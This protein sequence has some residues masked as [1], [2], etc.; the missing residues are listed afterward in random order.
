MMRRLVLI[1]VCLAA[2][3]SAA[4]TADDGGTESPFSL[5]AG[6]RAMGMGNG[7]VGLAD[8]ATAVYYNPAGLPALQTQ[9][10]SFLHTILFEETIYDFVSYVYPHKQ[11]A[12][13]IAGMRLGTDDIGRRDEDYYDLG[14]FDA[15]QMQLMISYGRRIMSRLDAGI[16]LKMAH[17][18][19]DTYSAYGYGL[20]IGGKIALL[21]QLTG[22][23]LLQDVIG[24]RMQL[25]NEKERTPFTLKMGLAYRL[26]RE[27]CPMSSNIVFD[28]DVPENRSTKLRTGLELMH[29]T[30]LSLRGGYDRD[31][32]TLGLGIRYQDLYFDYAYKFMENLDDSHRF[33]LTFN[34][35]LT[36]RE[37]EARRDEAARQSGDLLISENRRQALLTELRAAD[38][39]YAEGQYDSALAAYYRADAHAEDKTYIHTR[40]EDI[41]RR[42]SAGVESPTGQMIIIDSSAAVSGGSFLRQAQ[43]FYERGALVAARDMVDL[44]RRYSAG[45]PEL[46]TLELAV[47]IAI[48][49][50]INDNI[51]KAK[52]A[53][54]AGDYISA[55]DRY[56]TVLMYDPN[57]ALARTGSQMSEKRLDLAQHL[58]L[59]LEYFNQGKYISSQRAFNRALRV[60]PSNQTA[61]EYLQRIDSRIKESTSLDDLQKNARVWQMY[62][63]G[64]EAFRR[65]E[66]ETAIE[67]WEDVL[68][69]YPNNRNTIENI[70][71]ARLRLKK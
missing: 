23:V 30:G 11:G 16:S 4:W 37:S 60:D 32:L 24:A 58:N 55:Y 65:G 12:L 26:Q 34:F 7:F 38:R 2:F 48:E 50:A 41:K 8:D 53:F 68:E 39:F 18:S 47:N 36:R 13:G 44:A 1:L 69:V 46:D 62:L 5:G 20:D 31:N 54:G 28:V 67:L 35:G 19:I 10:I 17:H 27:G 52:S 66:Y 29:E 21:P 63:D 51:A 49:E 70:E 56:N 43:L 33:S 14:R 59:G 40:I 22:G 42:L 71:Q 3:A 57:N 64:L 45:S 25:I 15:S 61:K 6:A 9:Q